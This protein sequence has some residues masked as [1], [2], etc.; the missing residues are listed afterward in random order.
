MRFSNFRPVLLEGG[1]MFLNTSS[2]DQA[3]IPQVVKIVNDALRGA[4]LKVTPIGSGANPVKGKISNDFDVMADEDAVKAFFKTQDAKEA[5]RKLAEYLKNLGF[6]TAQS[7][8][9]VHILVPVGK[10]NI[11]TDIMVTPQ[12]E[13]IA[14]FHTH[15]IPAGSPFK[16]KNKVLTV[17]ILAK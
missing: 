16:G 11:Q 3:L 15:S 2:F 5:R 8:V 1:N 13:A 6:E 10:T 9:I 7:G 17:A 14:K 12:A 4:G